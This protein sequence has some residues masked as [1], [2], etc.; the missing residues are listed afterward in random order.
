MID[1]LPFSPETISIVSPKSW[2][3]VTGTSA[4]LPFATTA[5]RNPS[6][7]NSRV[8]TG[9]MNVEISVG[10]LKWTSAKEPES[11]WPVGLL[12]STSLKSVRVALLM[13][14]AVRTSFPGNVFPGN[15]AR[16]RVAV[17]PGL[18]S[19]EYSSGTLTN[20]RKTPGCEM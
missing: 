4:A 19:C 18:A 17:S 5:T 20:T 2:P 15:S 6:A 1:S 14:P 3:G 7:R 8:S 9:I 10:T 11:S 16:V 13:E 12:T